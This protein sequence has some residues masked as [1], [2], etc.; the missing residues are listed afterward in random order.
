M[1]EIFEAD[2]TYTGPPVSDAMVQR[3]QDR[4][5]FRLPSSYISMI[6]TRNGGVPRRRC[7][8]TEFRTSWA[9]DHFEINAILGIGGDF[10]IDADSAGSAYLISEWGYPD[11]G[12][13][14]CDTPSG[15]HDTV[16]LDYSEVGPQGEP[17]IV[18]VDEDRVPR[19]VAESFTR[20]VDGLAECGDFG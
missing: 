11:V 9:E 15:G 20:F 14:I 4:L 10:G 18:Y 12:V 2:D 8:R 17:S 7:F 13:V 3:A 1:S 16:M 5:G 6:M 19:R